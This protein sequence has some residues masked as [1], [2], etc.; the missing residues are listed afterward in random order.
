MLRFLEYLSNAK[1][2]VDLCI[3]IFTQPILANILSD[4]HKRGI[5]IRI[6]TDGSW[7]AT[8]LSRLDLLHNSGVKIKYN[9]HGTGALMHHKFLIIDDSFLL[10]GSFNWTSKAVT[11]NYEAVIITSNQRLVRSFSKKFD[12]M[13]SRFPDYYII[14]RN[15]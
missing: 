10:T 14:K 15:F 9:R 7:D 12:E 13:W 1:T 4:L 2:N 5:K 3:Y 6:I 8:T 11:S